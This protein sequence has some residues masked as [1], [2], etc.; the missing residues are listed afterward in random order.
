MSF[1]GQAKLLAAL[2]IVLVIVVLVGCASR[3]GATP[4]PLSPTPVTPTATA[5]PS[6]GNTA[7]PTLM[8]IVAAETRHFVGDPNAPVTIIEFGDFQ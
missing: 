4:E 8:D 6:V 1:T 5:G 3:P 2:M 7:T